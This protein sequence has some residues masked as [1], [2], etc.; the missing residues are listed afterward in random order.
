MDNMLTWQ[1]AIFENLADKKPFTKITWDLGQGLRSCVMKNV[2]GKKSRE[3]LPVKS[4]MKKTQKR[5]EEDG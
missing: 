1:F 3:T 5:A 2:S 4:G